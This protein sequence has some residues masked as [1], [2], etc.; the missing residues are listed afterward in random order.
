MRIFPCPV[1]VLFRIFYQMLLCKSD[2]EKDFETK[3]KG[4]KVH[5]LV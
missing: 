2:F 5:A 4:F 1:K 3:D